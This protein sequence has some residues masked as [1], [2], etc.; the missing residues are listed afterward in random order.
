MRLRRKGVINQL[1]VGLRIL[2]VL[3]IDMKT[4]VAFFC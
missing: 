3:K 2:S 1:F 4:I